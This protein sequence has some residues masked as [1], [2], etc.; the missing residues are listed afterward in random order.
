MTL[1]R[2]GLR[3][4][5]DS[6]NIVL[7]NVEC[8]ASV[9]IGAVVRMDS[10][11][12]KNALANNKANSNVIGVVQNKISSTRCDI[13]VTGI[14]PEIFSGLDDTKEYFLS[15]TVAGV[16]TTSIPTASGTVVVKIGQPFT[17]KMFL[18]LKQIMAVRA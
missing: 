4:N 1:I 5:I 17:D 9:F 18:V 13:R 2:G 14:T 8:E 3:P 15:D 6:L 16:I 12:A 7:E 10:G 11:I